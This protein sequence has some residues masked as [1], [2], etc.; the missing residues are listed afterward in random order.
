MESR[1]RA[2]RAAL[3]VSF[4][5]QGAIFALL[6]TR[7][8]AIQRQY[9]ISDGQL[10]IFLAAVPIL[11]GV[12]SVCSEQVVKRTT[13]R[14]VLRVVQPVVCLTLLGVGAG[15]SSLWALAISLAAFGLFTGGLDASMNM[16]GVGLQRRYG[17]PIMTGFHAAFSLGGIVGASLAWVDAHYHLSLSAVFTPAALV[18][19]AA[20]LIAGRWYAGPAE[21]GSAVAE[22]AAQAARTVPWK[23]LLPLCLAMC[24]AYIGDATVSN[25]S[26]KY[27]SDGLHSSDQL[28]TLPYN[29]YMVVM[30]VARALGDGR[31][32]RWGP[33]RVVLAGTVVCTLGF[34]LVVCAPGAWFAILGFAVVG[35]GIS[36]VV[37]QVFAAG[38]RRVPWASDA[39]VARLNIFNYAGFLVGSPL[40]GALADAMGYR[41]AMLVPTA[42]LLS[43][44][45]VVRSFGAGPAARPAAESGAVQPVPSET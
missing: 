6:V 2:A 3:A 42:M 28:S 15:G 10:P 33:V 32:R 4:L 27:L 14:A 36:V 18:V 8:P 17:R 20:V 22:A 39:A 19:A 23:P 45:L 44:V 1:L 38:G 31:V 40:V 16:L 25:W 43:L 7:I 12:G 37:P 21:L 34:V 41:L 13:P 29:A 24:F 30:L 35:L 11:A 5:G 9:G 26:A